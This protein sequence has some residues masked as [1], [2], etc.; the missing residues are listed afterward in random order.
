[1]FETLR[2]GQCSQWCNERCCIG[3]L[4]MV[5]MECIAFHGLA[6]MFR[7]VDFL[8]FFPY[9]ELTT[10]KIVAMAKGT[11]EGKSIKA[12]IFSEFGKRL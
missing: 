5:P 3:R 12:L 1:M 8:E 2:F 10:E 4:R 11:E 6:E 9:T 7:D